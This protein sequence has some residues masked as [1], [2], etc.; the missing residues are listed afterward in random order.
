MIIRAYSERIGSPS[1]RRERSSSV[2]SIAPV[3]E[4]GANE[5]IPDF[6]ISE[7]IAEEINE[8]DAKMT[9]EHCMHR[10]MY[11][12][13]SRRHV[14]ICELKTAPRPCPK[15]AKDK[16]DE[17][18]LFLEAEEQLSKYCA[19]YFKITDEDVDSVIAL[20]GAGYRWK[21]LEIPRETCP[22]Y[23]WST[24]EF[25]DD[26]AHSKSRNLM[27]RW[28]RAPAYDLHTDAS[29]QALGR[30]GNIVRRMGMNN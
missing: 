19:A 16:S 2:V 18:G 4:G 17:G 13:K 25:R 3:S 30:V 26:S 15:G 6:V 28:G 21:Y 9:D 27:R 11:K 5:F 23:N 1:E 7:C 29:N 20:L 10:A 12:A 14:L 24:S 22:E 8:S